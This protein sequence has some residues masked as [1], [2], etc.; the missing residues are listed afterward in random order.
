MD[1]EETKK[2][3]QSLDKKNFFNI[4]ELRNMPKY[5]GWVTHCISN[6][7]NIKLFLGGNDDG[8]ALRFFW[9]NHYEEQ[10]LMLWSEF[11]KIEGIVL[12]IGAHTGIYSLIA[13]C[14]INRGAVFSFEPYYMNFARLNLNL[15]ANSISTQNAFMLAVGSKNE[16][17]PFSVDPNTDYLTSGGKLGKFTK[18]KIMPVQT[19]K[20]D[21]FLDNEAQTHVKVI[22][23]DVEGHEFQCLKGMEMT[24]SKSKPIVFFECISKTNMK[25]IEKFL[26]KMNYKLF[27]IDDLNLKIREVSGLEP[28]FDI[29]GELQHNLINRIAIHSSEIN[30]IEKILT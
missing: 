12:D 24:L 22:K 10:T 17:L 27:L 6:S 4:V 11:T 3:R 9:N 16:K 1:N 13:N 20:I 14:S 15:R 23:I 28:F 29:N 30:I 7:L 25:L 19:I 18:K 8:V 5:F 2:Y 26:K 21:D